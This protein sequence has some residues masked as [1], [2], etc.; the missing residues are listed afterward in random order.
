[1]EEFKAA[2]KSDKGLASIAIAAELLANTTLDLLKE[3]KLLERI[4]QEHQEIVARKKQEGA[5]F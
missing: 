3:P 2:A 4:K 1:T 5:T